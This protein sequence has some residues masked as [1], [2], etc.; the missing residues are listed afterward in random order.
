MDRGQLTLNTFAD[1]LAYFRGRYVGADGEF[2]H[3]YAHLNLRPADQPALIGR[4]LCD[5]T[6]DVSEIAAGVLIIVYRYR[7]N[8]FHGEKWGYHLQGQRN[9]LAH[10]NAALMKAMEFYDVH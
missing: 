7:N 3:H 4:V 1:E 10:A 9:N 2:T 8:L 5:E 6:D